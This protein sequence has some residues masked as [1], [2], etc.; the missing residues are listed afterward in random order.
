[1]KK[2]LMPTCVCVCARACTHAQT[3]T[4]VR[5]RAHTH[6]CIHTSS[7]GGN[8]RGVTIRLGFGFYVHRRHVARHAALG[9]DTILTTRAS[10]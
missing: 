4:H 8:L 9:R 2:I 10:P 6:A 1:M 3:Y 5:S 7:L